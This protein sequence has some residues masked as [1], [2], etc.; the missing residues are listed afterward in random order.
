[1]LSYDLEI[2]WDN[3]IGANFLKIKS[4]HVYPLVS[5]RFKMQEG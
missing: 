3:A 5:L 2:I 1:M 4:W